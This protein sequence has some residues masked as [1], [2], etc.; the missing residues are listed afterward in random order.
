MRV[1]TTFTETLKKVL[2]KQLLYIYLLKMAIYRIQCSQ[3]YVS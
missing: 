2:K 3:D 1:R